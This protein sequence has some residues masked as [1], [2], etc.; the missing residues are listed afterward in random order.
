[1]RNI[2][3][4]FLVLLVEPALGAESVVVSAQTTNT[5][6]FYFGA[7]PDDWQLFMNPNDPSWFNLQMDVWTSDATRGIR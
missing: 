3:F 6:A 5:V 7:H 4:L 1:M 2:S